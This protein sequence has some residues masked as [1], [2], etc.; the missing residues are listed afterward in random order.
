[1]TVALW[2]YA[3]IRGG[4]GAHADSH[5]ARECWPQP[6]ASYR[7]HSSNIFGLSF[8]SSSQFLLSC[9]LDNVI[10]R[11]RVADAIGGAGG[12]SSG[13]GHGAGLAMPPAPRR[14]HSSVEF[15]VHDGAVYRAEFCD[16]VY[17]LAP[18]TIREALT[19]QAAEA[20]A[21][22]MGAEGAPGRKRQRQPAKGNLAPST[23][24]SAAS[25]TQPSTQS[26]SSSSSSSCGGPGDV[27][28]SVS[29]D[30]TARLWDVRCRG[31]RQGCVGVIACRSACT[32][33]SVCPADPRFFAVGTLMNSVSVFDM[34]SSFNCGLSGSVKKS[35][36]DGTVP[37][38]GA[39]TTY[40]LRHL[41]DASPLPPAAIRGAASYTHGCDSLMR[42]DGS[43]VIRSASARL[44]PFSLREVVLR[45]DWDTHIRRDR[46]LRGGPPEVTG[47]AFNSAGDMIAVAA[48]GTGPVILPFWNN[49][50]NSGY[51]AS[52]SSSAGSGP[53]AGRRSS[54]S[55]GA[56]AVA[57]D[58][59]LGDGEVVGEGGIV[60]SGTSI[61]RITTVS[62]DDDGWA[63]SANGSSNSSSSSSSDGGVLP[64][65]VCQAVGYENYSTVKVPTWAQDNGDDGDDCDHEYDDAMD[66]EDDGRRRHGFVSRRRRMEQQ[67]SSSSSSRRKGKQYV[68]CGSEDTRVYVWQV[69]SVVEDQVVT[70]A[71]SDR[72]GKG[73]TASAVPPASA[74]TA[75][76]TSSSS[77][78]APSL[79][80][81]DLLLTDV[82][83]SIAAA[84]PLYLL[85]QPS[86][87]LVGHGSI[88]NSVSHHPTLPL[89][90]S[91]GVEK[92]IRLWS[93]FASVVGP[94]R[95]TT[96][97]ELVSAP[98]RP[99]RNSSRT[100][101]TGGAG[102]GDANGLT[103]V[104]GDVDA[105]ARV[106]AQSSAAGVRQADVD[107]D[108]GHQ[109]NSA[110]A[111]S[112]PPGRIRFARDYSADVNYSTIGHLRQ[113]V[114]NR[115]MG[116]DADGVGHECGDNGGKVLQPHGRR[117]A[118]PVV[119]NHGGAGNANSGAAADGNRRAR[120][121]NSNSSG[122]D[123]SSDG[124]DNTSSDGLD[125]SSFSAS[126]V[127]NETSSSGSS[128]DSSSPFDEDD[129]SESIGDDDDADE[130]EVDDDVDV[131]S[132]S[133]TR[134]M[135]KDLIPNARFDAAQSRLSNAAVF[136][137]PSAIGNP[138]R[139]DWPPPVDAKRGH[140]GLS[141]RHLPW[142]AAHQLKAQEQQQH[143]DTGRVDGE[144]DA[145]AGDDDD[146]S[147]EDYHLPE[148]GRGDDED[149]D[150]GASSENDDD[151]STYCSCLEE[152]D[153]DD[154]IGKGGAGT[155]V[156]G[157]GP[158][159]GLEE[160][161][162]TDDAGTSI[163]A[164]DGVG[165]NAAAGGRPAIGSSSSSSSSAAPEASPRH[166]AK[167]PKKS[168]PAADASPG[169]IHLSSAT[170]AAALGRPAAAAATSA[171]AAAA[172]AAADVEMQT[173]IRML[174]GSS[175]GGLTA[176]GATVAP[177]LLMPATPVAAS[178]GRTKGQGRGVGLAAH[179][180]NPDMPPPPHIIH[181]WKPI[182]AA[183]TAASPGRRTT[184][185]RVAPLLVAAPAPAP[186]DEGAGAGA[187]V[188]S[189]PA[190]MVD[191]AVAKPD[192]ARS[193]LS[194]NATAA[195]AEAGPPYHAGACTPAI[196]QLC[197][198][199]M[200]A[201]F[202]WPFTDQDGHDDDEDVEDDDDEHNR[203]TKAAVSSKR[204]PQDGG[205]KGG[206][207]NYAVCRGRGR[208][209]YAVCRGRGRG[210]GAT[211]AVSALTTE[212]PRA[213]RPGVGVA[214]SASQAPTATSVQGRRRGAGAGAAVR[215]SVS[216]G[217]AASRA[218]AAAARRSAATGHDTKSESSNDDVSEDYEDGSGDS[219]SDVGGSSGNGGG[220]DSYSDEE[221][222]TSDDDE[223]DDDD[224]E[225]ADEDSED[226]DDDL[227][228]VEDEDGDDSGI[229][230]GSEDDDDE[231]DEEEDADDDES[232]GDG[233]DDDGM[234]SWL[235]DDGDGF[236]WEL[237]SSGDEDAA[238]DDGGSAFTDPAAGADDGGAN[239]TGAAGAGAA[240][241][242]G[243]AAQVQAFL[244]STDESTRVLSEFRLITGHSRQER[245]LT[246]EDADAARVITDRWFLRWALQRAERRSARRRLAA[247]GGS[248]AAALAN[249]P[250]SVS[251]YTDLMRDRR[252]GRWRSNGVTGAFPTSSAA[253]EVPGAAASS[254]VAT[255]LAQGAASTFLTRPLTP[256]SRPGNVDIT[257]LSLYSIVALLAMTRIVATRN[258]L[259]WM[260]A[261]WR[262]TTPMMQGPPT[263]HV[264]R[265]AMIDGGAGRGKG[266]AATS[267][268]AA[269]AG[270][271]AGT[272]RK[273][274]PAASA[275]AAAADDGVGDGN[276][277]E[278]AVKMKQQQ[279]RA[280][281][282]AP[283]LAFFL[284]LLDS[285]GPLPGG[286]GSPASLV[287]SSQASSM[288]VDGDYAEDGR[289]R[290]PSNG[291]GGLS[292]DY[293]ALDRSEALVPA[294]F[295]LLF[296]VLISDLPAAEALRSPVG[297]L[298][299]LHASDQWFVHLQRPMS[300]L[301]Q[302]GADAIAT[303]SG[304]SKRT[305][306]RAAAAARSSNSLASA[307]GATTANATAQHALTRDARSFIWLLRQLGMVRG[308][309]PVDTWSWSLGLSLSA[310][311]G[312]GRRST[313]HAQGARD[314]SRGRH[315]Q[316]TSSSFVV[317]DPADGDA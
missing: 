231:E 55:V 264:E 83:A 169:V 141:D 34:R 7:G 168:T 156:L 52:R 163:D 189:T 100:G 200:R 26:T 97:A 119:S 176:A 221:S 299:H 113:T 40:D 21:A 246:L 261:E 262:S 179:R 167:R 12:G 98:E 128:S 42:G 311:S 133:E 6:T 312:V 257:E 260:A 54:P 95:Q 187:G 132:D 116:L 248:V 105:P 134:E 225:D 276:V 78:S 288:S 39:V 9:G 137:A 136:P 173:A 135:I 3:S 79:S 172:A 35:G 89:L 104:A 281:A 166:A 69:P 72:Y 36:A 194:S 244:T 263:S 63:S 183:F 65:A 316:G 232:L 18:S 290:G 94:A 270:A 117:S 253:L 45:C 1:M 171:A 85:S 235:M 8:D 146:D 14:L 159:T 127:F 195:A 199:H 93:P 30:T 308:L 285:I 147:D 206:A 242:G 161:E 193:A 296:Q 243:T 111:Q 251:R 259:A 181:R 70:L 56:A 205:D 247:A 211:A 236:G 20:T 277:T 145:C 286:I 224:E 293:R 154:G 245:L 125:T 229:S 201:A 197:Q 5:A 295:R 131:A 160:E 53:G 90:A 313:A 283:R 82:A 43:A 142:V 214:A 22:A 139:S 212:R 191:A 252:G 31:R 258:I 59:G 284:A 71:L 61:S 150:G 120:Q 234:D 62:D 249:P 86:Q 88:P 291:D 287:A 4:C 77:A 114:L 174:R 151:A 279:L 126:G 115:A 278:T 185:R 203:R 149:G 122:P 170:P 315:Q 213:R 50:R 84:P 204:K 165:A 140:T 29:E 118:P 66:G 300:A 230:L 148:H 16:S 314:L 51:Y 272:K 306:G 177:A 164:G 44:D 60:F 209:N 192:V 269:S 184:L 103:S 317:F 218:G 64:L 15:D 310:S 124:T 309:P 216:R 298:A 48:K 273:R 25:K 38:P 266:R 80:Q 210:R 307:P 158:W 74:A 265:T 68:V 198:V 226:D 37:C 268:N 129:D 92:S 267:T 256:P 32:G 99:R 143:D 240:G 58:G 24:S 153:E 227:E 202:G 155:R 175:W 302:S 219:G 76:A 289:A 237:G 41:P 180:A 238:D 152:D 250:P 49:A 303:G 178:A 239:W 11:H 57:A 81:Q 196:D 106:H 33:L 96:E 274:Q 162:D 87:V 190:V 186:P 67:C 297:N 220:S 222:Y 188:A 254:A 215:G 223:D 304:G 294:R 123:G 217:R 17:T 121:H 23:S 112:L 10:M 292:I 101:N 73:T 27:F 75:A 19:Q 255:S 228:A 233:D 102:G 28:I 138:Q 108:D 208:G 91:S 110:N 157:H 305:G 47:I 46:E 2:K 13:I 241:G 280:Q 107:S 275:A 144:L 271:G 130:F 207:S 301:A 182:E 109:D 282:W